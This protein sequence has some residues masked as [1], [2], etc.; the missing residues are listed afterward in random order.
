MSSQAHWFCDACGTFD[1]P[2]TSRYCDVCSDG[3]EVEWMV[4]VETAAAWLR[5]IHRLDEIPGARLG[6]PAVNPLWDVGVA[7][8]KKFGGPNSG[9]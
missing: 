8:E 6:F 4:P 2:I 9:A 5:H 7:F 1:G 3:S